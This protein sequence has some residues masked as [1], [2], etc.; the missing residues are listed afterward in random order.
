MAVPSAEPDLDLL[1][2]SFRQVADVLW[3]VR[4]GLLLGPTLMGLSIGRTGRTDEAIAMTS[5]LIG[6]TVLGLSV[7]RLARHRAEQP[8]WRRA[9]VVVAVATG[10]AW[11]SAPFLL[12]AD[13]PAA[14]ISRVVPAIGVI[15]MTSVLFAPYLPGF[16]G[17]MVGIVAPYTVSLVV[18]GHDL[19]VEA[20]PGVLTVAG[21]CTA[22]AVWSNRR[23]RRALLDRRALEELT[24]R[25]QHERGAALAA[26]ERLHAV[27]EHVRRLAERD[28]LTGAYNRR[29]LVE[30]FDTIGVDERPRHVLVLLDLDHFK[31]ANDRFGHLMGD[32][33]LV[34]LV[35]ATHELLPPDAFVARWGGEEFAVLV[36]ASVPTALALV[37]RVRAAM[38]SRLP[39]GVT[40]TF[41]AGLAHWSREIDHRELLRRADDALYAAKANGRNRT[42]VHQGASVPGR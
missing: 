9:F 22:Q 27:N 6:I 20:L 12:D 13:T 8:A 19:A 41:S 16:V 10:A 25:L 37:D 36:P 28:H 39:S 30:R 26:N 23:N 18:A 34:Q 33:I 32:E 14:A 31:A 21:V 15:A 11:G 5:I 29:V 40:T 42:E 24:Q 2:R 4:V 3:R 1:T 17:V 38:A 7:A 35:A